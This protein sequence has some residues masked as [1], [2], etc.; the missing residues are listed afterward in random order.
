MLCT[1]LLNLVIITCMVFLSVTFPLCFYQSRASKPVKQKVDNKEEVYDEPDPVSEEQI[2]LWLIDVLCGLFIV[3]TRFQT[4][5]QGRMPRRNS[6]ESIPMCS[7]Q[8]IIN[9]LLICQDMKLIL[10][11]F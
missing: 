10:S 5:F 9:F 11:G 6:K 3:V 2:F 7:H 1:S 4:R 8:S